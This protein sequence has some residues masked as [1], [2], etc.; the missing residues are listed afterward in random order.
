MCNVSGGAD[1]RP[2]TAVRS[3]AS[4][5]SSSATRRET[6]VS[7][8]GPKASTPVAAQQDGLRTRSR[9]D[10]LDTGGDRGGR[11]HRNLLRLAQTG[12]RFVPGQQR[13]ARQGERQQV[14]GMRVDHRAGLW[15]GPVH[16][17]V[18]GHD[19]GAHPAQVAFGHAPVDADHDE[20]I[21]HEIACP[22]DTS[23]RPPG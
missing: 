7:A 23:V 11:G 13:P 20:V 8:S 2:R 15:P 9:L 22:Y 12:Q 1:N 19:L 5:A 14:R 3:S 6:V 10:Q 18:H 4:A 21:G 17:R 16:L